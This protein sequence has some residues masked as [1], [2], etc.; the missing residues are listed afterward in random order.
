MNKLTQLYCYVDETGQDTLGR[1]FLVSIVIIEK[2]KLHLENILEQI[3]E[4]S[5]KRKLKW[6]KTKR[7]R[8]IN[9]LNSI[10]KIKDFQK[11]FYFSIY[12][13]TNLFPDLIVL[14]TAKAIIDKM[15]N[16]YKA[17]IVID[18]LSKNLERR[19]SSSLRKLNI[20]VNKVKGARDESS[21]LI[22]LAD[23]L[24]GLLRDAYEG[25]QLFKDYVQRF[26]NKKYIKEI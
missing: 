11:C 17:N 15:K 25:D 9:Y 4:L 19:F 20:K 26:K 8:R 23:A 5:G 1:W 21:S 3:E 7:D 12:K 2:D 10:I 18:G 22:R 24:A 14:A 16:N 13:N 6:N